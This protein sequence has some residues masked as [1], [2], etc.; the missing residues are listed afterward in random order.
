M[1]HL[2][3]FKSFIKSILII[4]ILTGL[5]VKVSAQVESLRGFTSDQVASQKKRETTF[6]ATPDPK[7]L[8]DYMQ[9]ISAEPHHAGSP[10]SKK[11]AEFILSKFKEWGLNAWIEQQEALMPFPVERLLELQGPEPYRAILQEPVIPEDI[12]S[13]DEGGLPPYNAYSAD[14]D[15]TAKLVFVNYGIPEDY[16]TLEKLGIDVT[17]KIVIAK[18]GRSWRG[19]KP[20]VAAEHG[21]IGCIIYS[22]P[23]DDGYFQGDV[24]PKG[25]WKPWKGVQRGSVMDMPTHP[26][27]PLTPGWGSEPGGKRL[28]RAEAKTLMRIPVLPISYHDAKPLLLSLRGPVA[29]EEWRGA[30]PLTYHVGPSET[31]V[32]L[33]LSFDWQVRPLY[34]VFARI[35]GSTFPDEWIINGNH[36]DA[37][38]NGAMD[39]TSGN[40]SLMETARGLSELVRQGWKPQRTIIFASWDGEEWGLLGSTEWAE[41]H[42]KELSDKVAVYINT[43]TTGGGWFSAAGSHS[44]QALVTEVVGDLEGPRGSGGT[45]LSEARTHLI[46]KA[47]TDREKERLIA[48]E[49][50]P[51]APIGGGSD[52]TVFLDH[53]TIASLDLNFTDEL[54]GYAGIYHSAYDSFSW[55]TRFGD[56]D[57]SFGKTLSKIV[58]TIILR[59]ADSTVLPFQ[60]VD[61][62]ETISMY[63]EE[64]ERDA[65]KL[66]ESQQLDFEPLR[67]SLKRLN[68]AAASYELVLKELPAASVS[69]LV[70][71]EDSLHALNKLLY[72]SERTLSY[73]AGLPKREWF[74][75]LV[76][77]PGFYTGY[78]VKTLPGIREGLEQNALDEALKFISVVS[79]SLDDL[80]G[81]IESAE[82]ALSHLLQ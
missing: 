15:I 12:D 58:G 78:G 1:F 18:Y 38:V 7:N 82:T 61:Y 71:K 72:R 75:H 39:P 30:L 14:G 17:G 32:H 56:P 60:F 31:N 50:L 45:V 33:K 69:T 57:F 13:S 54:D 66:D 2:R 76:Y 51:L 25:P 67:E 59:L 28:D 47:E 41:R 37:W 40:V 52:Y 27:D 53:L 29:P 4:G 70:A 64:L 34:N 23:E 55:Y 20:K 63:V 46:E 42:A 9:I 22:D 6:Q 68:K 65:S 73:T 5:N 43:D 77:A 80:S 26:G 8:R 21:A 81:Q 35:D 24:Y 74:K 36:H 16:D 48:R 49:D 11:V 19:I 62:A 79:S 3:H 44:L 10:G